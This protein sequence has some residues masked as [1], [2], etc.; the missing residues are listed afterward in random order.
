MTSR[1]ERL[2]LLLENGQSTFLRK[3]AAHQIGE[4]VRTHPQEFGQLINK[5]KPLIQNS[6]WETRI[7]ASQ[8][9]DVLVKNILE[10]LWDLEWIVLLNSSSSSSSGQSTTKSKNR[11][12]NNFRRE[13]Q[14]LKLSCF[15]LDELLRTSSELLSSDKQKYEYLKQ[16]TSSIWNQGG[17][18]GQGI[19][20]SSSSSSKMAAT[21]VPTSPTS[22]SSKSSVVPPHQQELLEQ[23]KLQ[24]KLVNQKLGIDVSGAANL[25]TKHIF[26][27]DDLLISSTNIKEEDAA[28]PSYGAIK[29]NKD[30][31][32][33]C[34]ETDSLHEEATE[35]CAKKLKMEFDPLQSPSMSPSSQSR[36]A[37]AMTTQSSV[38]RANSVTDRDTVAE[39]DELGKMKQELVKLVNWLF[40]K[41]FDTEWETRHG[42]ACGLRELFKQTSGFLNRFKTQYSSSKNVVANGDA[43]NQVV[44]LNEQVNEWLDRSLTRLLMVI[45]LDK[46][47][48]FV[49]D[50]AVAPVRETAAQ[51][52]GILANH[53]DFTILAPADENGHHHQD[54]WTQLQQLC[55][56]INEFID[57][58]KPVKSNQQQQQSSSSSSENSSWEI[59]HSGIMILKYVIASIAAK[60]NVGELLNYHLS[61]SKNETTKVQA[62]Q[63][64]GYSKLDTIMKINYLNILKC[65]QDEDDD[66]RH[67]ASASLESISKLL[68]YLLNASDL[69]RLIRTLIEVLGNIDELS[70]SCS[71]IMCLLSNLL[72]YSSSTTRNSSGGGDQQSC[73]SNNNSSNILLRI[74][75]GQSILPRLLP[76]LQHQSAYVRQTTLITINKMLVSIELDCPG[77]FERIEL[78]ASTATEPSAQPLISTNL[79][80][81]FRLLYQQAILLSSD[82]QFRQMEVTIEQ[83]W[84][85]LCT[86]LSKSCLLSICFPYISTW[87]LL[88]MH[89]INQPIDP[90]H[91]VKNLSGANQPSTSSEFIGSNL[92]KYEERIERD[93][94]ILKCRLLAARLLSILFARISLIDELTAS[95]EKPI[96]VINKYLSTQLNFKSGLHRFC[97]AM[98]LH[99][100][101]SLLEALAKAAAGDN[102]TTAVQRCS[103]NQHVAEEKIYFSNKEYLFE[104]LNEAQMKST[105]WSLSLITKSPSAFEQLVKR[106]LDCLDDNTTIYYDE[107]ALSFTRL[108]KECKY[109]VQ[110]AHNFGLFAS[111]QQPPPPAII[112][113]QHLAEQEQLEN[114]QFVSLAQLSVYTFEDASNLIQLVRTRLDAR[115]AFPS[116]DPVVSKRLTKKVAEDM[117]V[118]ICNLSDLCK[119]TSQDQDQLQMRSSS[120][121]ASATIALGTLPEKMNPLVRPLID[122][123]RM[124]SNFSLQFLAAKFLS[125]LL[126]T[127]STRQPNP[128]PKIFK[129]LLS[130]L[131][132]DQYQTPFIKQMPLP[133]NESN[134]QSVHLPDK[135]FYEVNR[136]FGILGDTSSAAALVSSNSASTTNGGGN[137]TP[138]EETKVKRKASLQSQTSVPPSPG[139][140]YQAANID[141]QLQQLKSAIERRGAQQALRSIAIIYNRVSDLET[142]IPDIVQTPLS[143]LNKYYNLF[144]NLDELHL[145][146]IMSLNSNINKQSSSLL[147]D[148]NDLSYLNKLIESCEVEQLGYQDLINSLNLI[149]YLTST[150]VSPSSPSHQKCPL[151]SSE[152][153]SA[154]HGG[155]GCLRRTYVNILLKCDPNILLKIFLFLKCPFTAVRNAVARCL[156]SVCLNDVRSS[157]ASVLNSNLLELLLYQ[158]DNSN[159]N[160][161]QRQGV[162]EFVY[163][164]NKRL[165]H[166][167]IPYIVLFI[168]PVLKL[169][170]DHDFY[171]RSMSSYCFANLI[172]MYP[173][174]SDLA[175]ARLIEEQFTANKNLSQLRSRQQEFLDQLMDQRK[176]KPYQIPTSM[177]KQVELRPYQQQGI[178]WLGFLKQYNLNGILCDDMGL[179][180]TLQS[181][182]ILAGD[183]Y[184]KQTQF[185]D[186]LSE[187]KNN[188]TAAADVTPESEVQKEEVHNLDD[189]LLPS[190]I[191]CPTTL[192]NHWLH[193]INRFVDKKCL[194]PLIYSGSVQ[195]RE[196][197]RKRFFN[198]LVS[199]PTSS[200]SSSRLSKQASSCTVQQQPAAG[201]PCHNVLIISYD[202]IRHD[203]G[204]LEDKLWNYCVLDEGHLIKSS[205]TK[206]SKAIK[207]IKAAHRLILSGTPIQNNLTELWCLFDF[208]MPGY[209]G[210]E[211]Q[212]HAKYSKHITPNMSTATTTI[213][214]LASQQN[215][216]EDN[217]GSTPAAVTTGGGGN[218]QQQQMGIIALESLH[219]QVLPFLLRR[220][221]EEVLKDLP[222]KI[223]QD[224]YCEMSQ[225]QM[226][227][228]QDFA[229]SNASDNVK[230]TLGIDTFSENELDDLGLN[231]DSSVNSELKL[232][233]EEV[234]KEQK[235]EHVFHALQYLRKV[236]N[237]PSL[238]LK[239][240]HPKWPAYEKDKA[241][242]SDYRHS[243]KLVA[244]RDLLME[245]G[246]GNG[247]GG[248]GE[249]SSGESGAC[250]QNGGLGVLNQHRVLI[251]CQLK[252]MIELIENELLKKMANVSYLRLDGT[253]APADRF[254]IV[255]RFNMDPSIDILLLTTQIGGLGLTLTGADTV[256][257][258]E[259]DWNPQKDLQAMDRAHRIGQ[260]RVVNVYRLITKRTIEEK[261]M[262]LQKFK[263]GIANSVVNIE[264]SSLASMGTEQLMNMFDKE[265]QLNNG[266]AGKAS[267]SSSTAAADNTPVPANAYQKLMENISDLWDESQYENEFDMSNFIK[268]LN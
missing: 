156:S 105:W 122:C 259:H 221:K 257:F 46:F 162:I 96:D 139:N 143:I 248:S 48:D 1:L 18:G 121:L 164:L 68:S 95:N 167:I 196:N 67:A 56:I 263:L 203:I 212:F 99:E 226:E 106:L 240:E 192:T 83:L 180:K 42:A 10:Q 179:G 235:Q 144:N 13:K 199:M 92:I 86:L 38:E 163:F 127:C 134:Q 63:L 262:S 50:E 194:N 21:S 137:S 30:D 172:R 119:Q 112:Q 80:Q 29:R 111:K 98:L 41:L 230:K 241:S 132:N 117:R 177:L 176:L 44:Y 265:D 260:K 207:Q 197:L 252:S 213:A 215:G 152:L 209:L 131:C 165:E 227:L 27:D 243:G 166:L 125:I 103:C 72:T 107:I 268:S 12:L 14:Q 57:I 238:V 7:A 154:D 267:S 170:C 189:L 59:R 217:E 100:W 201:S 52:I 79:Q 58:K 187:A 128:V 210:T 148:L 219:K 3:S 43:T 19:A 93:K 206:L 20:V 74:L 60:L 184:E 266:G 90:V 232:A 188:N 66:V 97:F 245:C 246:I 82:Q 36:E 75:N 76:F 204:Y 126:R 37:V 129:N 198:K 174:S 256:I 223:I 31:S 202:I 133:L 229:K 40:D 87:M 25:D 101:G 200:S 15:N 32:D 69:E 208:L 157:S 186:K 171:I 61:S 116:V 114:S 54:K 17:G 220:T 70:T 237:H 8:T 130:Y 51:I 261:I 254:G 140:G 185:Q 175:Q 191:V 136:Y 28:G 233:V 250:D 24:R 118:L 123:I 173:L 138:S 236:C 244:L 73:L 22:S 239:P 160:L 253:V 251:F 78:A 33:T 211:K 150:F 169:M 247:E 146:Q 214:A 84:F 65:L 77:N 102:S 155:G 9:L 64:N 110:E 62:D 55:L 181:I 34:S 255:N 4:I 249:L 91:L 45:A 2:F 159:R 108:Q 26:S 205:K 193:E 39:V 53:L 81:L 124:E 145:Q 88:F 178:N 224:Y 183:H 142:T 151:D 35:L 71:N 153:V 168:I 5:L 47:A 228:Y 231:I 218:Q 161:F 113:Q 158:L 89:P 258:V 115:I 135:E 182:C 85:N 141:E 225:L 104:Y 94:I 6:S 216:G 195:E 109:L 23:I 149:E 16:E 264:N 242:L 120:A 49:G 147:I 234:K 11:Q 222:P 190:L